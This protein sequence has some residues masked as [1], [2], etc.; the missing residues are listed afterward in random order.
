MFKLKNRLDLCGGTTS[1]TR[2]AY[3]FFSIVD[4]NDRECIVDASYVLY[5]ILNEE[6]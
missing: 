6:I 5:R 2:R 3:I 1:R 4:S